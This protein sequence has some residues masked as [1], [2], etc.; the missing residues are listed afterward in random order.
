MRPERR[1]YFQAAM[2]ALLTERAGMIAANEHRMS[3]G[4]GVDYGMEAFMPIADKLA[5][6]ALQLKG[7]S[8]AHKG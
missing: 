2:E 4:N 1:L 6:L 8:D 3:N 7:E 5:E